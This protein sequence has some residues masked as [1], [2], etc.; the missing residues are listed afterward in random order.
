MN[1]NAET[2]V[3]PRVNTGLS[4]SWTHSHPASL[5]SVFFHLRPPLQLCWPCEK[6]CFSKRKRAEKEWLSTEGIF[7]WRLSASRMRNLNDIRYQTW[8]FMRKCRGYAKM[9][10]RDLSSFWKNKRASFTVPLLRFDR[11]MLPY[12]I[13]AGV[14]HTKRNKFKLLQY[15]F[16]VMSTTPGT[17][18]L[19]SEIPGCVQRQCAKE[20]VHQ[21]FWRIKRE[22]S[23]KKEQILIYLKENIDR[24]GHK[25]L[26][27]R[28]A[29]GWR[30]GVLRREG[31]TCSCL[32]ISGWSLNRSFQAC[33]VPGV[34]TA[35]KGQKYAQLCDK[36]QEGR[37]RLQLRV[38]IKMIND[39]F[40]EKCLRLW[41]KQVPMWSTDQTWAYTV[42]ASWRVGLTLGA[43]RPPG[44]SL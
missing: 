7:N 12:P 41:Q 4:K 8:T 21:R 18:R 25:S 31:S 6:E 32:D 33:R 23:S 3:F 44:W 26:S 29:R 42:A 30:T 24:S 5:W 35:G 17:S 37:Y 19:W 9:I 16:Q 27:A 28:Q 11:F 13:D 15:G 38:P 39:G 22:V 43:W 2:T 40:T 10:S 34:F 14:D 1:Q 36:A 20:N